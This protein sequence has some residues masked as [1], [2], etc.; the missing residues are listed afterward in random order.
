MIDP[1]DAAIFSGAVWTIHS[2]RILPLQ[3]I[4]RKDVPALP[5][6]KS[7]LWRDRLNKVLESQRSRAITTA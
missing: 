7:T 5:G 6:K 2:P 1:H 3:E 4:S